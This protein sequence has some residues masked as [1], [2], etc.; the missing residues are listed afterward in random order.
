M[1]CAVFCVHKNTFKKKK[2][3]LKKLKHLW[4]TKFYQ[5]IMI[6]ISNCCSKFRLKNIPECITRLLHL[7][8]RN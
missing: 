2:K 7:T 8:Y 3:H 1:T 5:L 6:L 4:F